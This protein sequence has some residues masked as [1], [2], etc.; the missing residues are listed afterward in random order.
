MENEQNNI[1]KDL[2]LRRI[3]L[4]IKQWQVARQAGICQ[5]VL[6]DY[7][8]G[9]RRVTPEIRE[10]I[11]AAIRELAGEGSKQNAG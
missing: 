1:G 10:K 5:T 6:S 8:T 9:K 2:A 4:G 11:E 7:E 3:C